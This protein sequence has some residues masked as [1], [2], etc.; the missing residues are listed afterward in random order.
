M[1]PRRP[2]PALVGGGLV[3]AFLIAVDLVGALLSF[4]SFFRPDDG[5]ALGLLSQLGHDVVIG[6]GVFLVL[7]LLSPITATTKI[8]SVFIAGALA[9][10][11][12]AILAVVFDIF[13]AIAFARQMSGSLYDLIDLGLQPL[14]LV[15]SAIRSALYLLPLT[16][17][18]AVLVREWLRSRTA[19]DAPKEPV[20]AV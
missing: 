1:S 2:L 14:Q 11:G 4:L 19:V 7:W 13:G 18:A 6:L 8:G 10:A 17:L 3:A 5:F 20:A 15:T 12:G 9:A 16:V